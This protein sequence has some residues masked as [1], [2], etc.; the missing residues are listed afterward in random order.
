MT[1]GDRNALR[2]WLD[3]LTASNAIKKSADTALRNQFG[4]SISRFDV[5]A[6]LDRANGEGLR[7]GDLSQRLMVTEGNTTQVTA[8]LIRDGLV[9]RTPSRNDGRVAIFRLTRK[10]AKLFQK[11]ADE[12]R[13]WVAGAFS[14]LSPGELATLRRLLGKLN[15][16]IEIEGKDAA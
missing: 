15:L 9:K 12:H 5:M 3:L 7:A 6:A 10:G 11:M 16:P 8:P 13:H 2:A 4:V 14:D 1:N